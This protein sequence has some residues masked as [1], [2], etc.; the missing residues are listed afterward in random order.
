M[1]GPL[2]GPRAATG[3]AIADGA[4][5]ALSRARG[6][7]GQIRVRGVYLDDTEDG[8][9]SLA[10]TA[11]N[12]R[13]A[14][15]DVTAIGYIGELDSGSTRVSLP[16]TNQAGIAQV[17]AGSTAVDLTRLPPVGDARPE[18]LLPSEDETFARVVPDD[19]V[20]ARAAAVWAERMGASRVGVVSDGS[21]FARVLERS[22]LEQAA[23]SGLGSGEGSGVDLIYYAGEPAGFAEA[24]RGL[25]PRPVIGSDALISPAFLRSA[26]PE[27]DRLYLTSPFL[28]PE[29]LPPAG[30]RFLRAFRAP[31]WAPGSGG[32][33]LRLRGD[34]AD[35]RRDPPG[36]G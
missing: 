23:R 10:R 1:S 20:Q 28:D 25:P 19:E 31:F 9:L 7:A 3:R 6:R 24:L 11:A 15:A 35:A 18:R 17:S 4:R 34:V 29:L 2:E 5:L 8:D 14:T 26:A 32:R 36:R 27:A 33:R 16:I 30:Q 13:R 21:Q 22:F 12:A